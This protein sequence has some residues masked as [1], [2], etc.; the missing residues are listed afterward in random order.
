MKLHIQLEPY[1]GIKF[2]FIEVE[3]SS[4]DEIKEVYALLEREYKKPQQQPATN[5]NK[6]EVGI[7]L[8][9]LTENTINQNAGYATYKNGNLVKTKDGRYLTTT[10]YA[11]AIDNKMMPWE[12]TYAE[13]DA[14]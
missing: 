7:K 10:Q 13:I 3:V 8:E 11:K 14:L 9:R 4:V 2:D 1:N 5:Y 12:K 6:Q